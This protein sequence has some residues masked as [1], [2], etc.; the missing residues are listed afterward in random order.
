MG[1]F[2]LTPQAED[3]FLFAYFG[4][5]SKDI[6]DTDK[7]VLVKGDNAES[8]AKKCAYR[9]YLDMCRTLTYQSDKEDKDK[10]DAVLAI[11]TKFASIFT[12]D[13]KISIKREEAYNHLLKQEEGKTLQN[14]LTTP[15]YKDKKKRNTSVFYYGQAQKWINMT[16][17]YMWFIG[18]LEEGVIADLEVPLD[19]YIMKAASREFKISFP[20][21]D[22]GSRIPWSKL[23]E[24]EYNAIRKSLANYSAKWECDAWIAQAALERTKDTKSIALYDDNNPDNKTNKDS[25]D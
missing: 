12:S 20:K 15:T 7:T 25:M 18:L 2:K 11:C 23:Y 14:L 24:K 16:L 4:I 21:D 10:Q 5:V 1:E 3:F 22:G 6:Y 13:K 9:A 19:S 17:K 8:A